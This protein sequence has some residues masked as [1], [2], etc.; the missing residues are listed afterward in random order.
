MTTNETPHPRGTSRKRVRSLAGR[1]TRLAIAITGLTGLA[2]SFLTVPSNASA[3]A[4]TAVVPLVL[5]SAQGYDHQMA[6]A[7]TKATGIPVNLDDDSTGPLLTKIETEGNN[8][9]WNIFWVD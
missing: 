2:T 7:F 3:A 5:Y 6:A 9:Q 8:P 4:H 1:W